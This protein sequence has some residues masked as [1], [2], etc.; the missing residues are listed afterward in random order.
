MQGSRLVIP[1]QLQG[2]MRL[3]FGVPT[4]LAR[5]RGSLEFRLLCEA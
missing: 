5:T 2:E 1:F 4:P 3:V